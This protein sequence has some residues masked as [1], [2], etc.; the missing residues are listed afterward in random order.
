MTTATVTMSR[1]TQQLSRA[2]HDMSEPR[3]WPSG[4]IVL[5]ATY[6][7]LSCTDLFV[8]NTL[9]GWG[10]TRILEKVR[11]VALQLVT[12][13]VT[14]TGTL[15]Q[16]LDLKHVDHLNTIAVRLRQVERAVVV[17]VW[18][19]SQEPPIGPAPAGNQSGFFMP[20]RGGK[21][22][23]TVVEYPLCKRKP[24]AS[25]PP[26]W[27]HVTDQPSQYANDPETIRRVRMALNEL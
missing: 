10:L 4:S 15:D 2:E 14:T 23:W 9:A 20:D 21:V 1:M 27:H 19:S 17:E 26:A 22:V 25:C 3:R 7:A 18:D 16:H 13:A 24:A 8:E 6:T 12:N 5:V 11:A